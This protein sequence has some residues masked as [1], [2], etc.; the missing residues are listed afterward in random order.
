MAEQIKEFV[1]PLLKP[2][3]LTSSSFRRFGGATTIRE[4]TAVVGTVETVIAPVNP[5]R[6][7]M[8][9]VNNSDQSVYGSFNPGVGSTQGF[10][11][12]PNGGSVTLDLEYDGQGIAKPIYGVVTT[13]TSQITII[14]TVYL[15]GV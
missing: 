9:V 15:E 7:A 5:N 8:T 1:N 10:T 13:G 6:A 4:S 2:T 3:K 14:E 12:P 11:I